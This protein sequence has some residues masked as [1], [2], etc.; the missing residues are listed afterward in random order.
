MVDVKGGDD[1]EP[2]VDLHLRTRQDE[3][4]ALGVDANESGLGRNRLQNLRHL[5]CANVLERHDDIGEASA[6][7]FGILEAGS[8]PA[9]FS[10]T[11][12]EQAIV[13][14]THHQ[15]AVVMK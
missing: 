2:T 13:G 6:R 10:R 5:G 11:A 12:N 3:Q 7:T 14:A 8:H 1:V 4:I 9:S 15:C